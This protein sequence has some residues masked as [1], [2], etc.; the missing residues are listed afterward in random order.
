MTVPLYCPAL[1]RLWRDGLIPHGDV[2][3]V[4]ADHT[5]AGA[6]FRVGVCDCRPFISVRQEAA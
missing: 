3:D 6:S 5:G 1:L 2:V 4:D